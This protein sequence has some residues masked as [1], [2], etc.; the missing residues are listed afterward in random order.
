MWW[1]RRQCRS[2]KRKAPILRWSVRQRPSSWIK[3]VSV[4]IRNYRALQDFSDW[5]I[6]DLQIVPYIYWLIKGRQYF[7]FGTRLWK[8]FFTRFETFTFPIPIRVGKNVPYFN[9]GF[10]SFYSVPLFVFHPIEEDIKTH[11]FH[12]V[13][14]NR[15]GVIRL[16]FFLNVFRPSQLFFGKG[17]VAIE[18]HVPKIF[19]NYMPIHYYAFF[20]VLNLIP[21]H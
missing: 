4:Q 7:T 14:K 5:C 1:R 13:T 20:V 2:E 12:N 8:S 11:N 9:R 18:A 15:F 6:V 10:F 21:S 3:N 17:F 16:G 19:N